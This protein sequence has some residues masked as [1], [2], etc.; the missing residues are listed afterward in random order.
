[1]I[2]IERPNGGDF[3]RGYDTTVRGLSSHFVWLNRGKESLTL[4]LKRWSITNMPLPQLTGLL[5]RKAS[6][7]GFHPAQFSTPAASWRWNSD[8]ES[9]CSP[10]FRIRKNATSASTGFFEGALPKGPNPIDHLNLVGDSMLVAEV[11]HRF[12]A[13]RHC[14]V[15]VDNDKTAGGQLVIERIQ[16]N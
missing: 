4:D 1:M 10:F 11:V 9:A 3:A 7:A 15:I 2:K 12:S 5:S 6:F 8:L 16:C 14:P 13:T